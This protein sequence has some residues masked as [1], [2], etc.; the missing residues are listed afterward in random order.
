MILDTLEQAHRYE[1]LA[2]GISRGL[3]FLRDLDPE[4]PEGRH[5][6]AGEEVFALVSRY[7]T[8]PAGERRFEAHR[9]HLDL[10]YVAAGAERILH[11]P[12]VA[13]EVETAYSEE[14]DVVFFHDPKASSSLLLPAGG[15]AFLFPGDAHKP[16]CMAGG[17]SPVLKVVVKVRL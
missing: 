14:E 2:P 11:A 10:Q 3:A 15:V 7:E 8:G 4:I 12:A 5:D 13:L 1:R 9:R 17:R 6:V 16:G